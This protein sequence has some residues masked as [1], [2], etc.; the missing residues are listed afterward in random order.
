MKKVKENE[1]VYVVG[2][3]FGSVPSE[4]CWVSFVLK[5]VLIN[6]LIKFSF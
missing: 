4:N 1:N 2:N 5:R 3:F 6:I